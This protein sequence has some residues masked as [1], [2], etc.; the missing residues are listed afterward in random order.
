M[1]R[2]ALRA[3][4]VGALT[5]AIVGSAAEDLW[6][7]PCGESLSLSHAAP[8]YALFGS[9]ARNR[10]AYHRRAGGHGLGH[11]EFLRYLDFADRWL[12]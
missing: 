10:T 6:A 12:R 9:E 2:L 3:A 11:A 5:L 1:Q 7:D 8:V 4:V